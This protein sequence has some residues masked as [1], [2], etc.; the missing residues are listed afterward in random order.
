MTRTI[1][2]TRLQALIEIA[3]AKGGECLSTEYINAK[4]KMN[5]CCAEGHEW[6]ADADQI[7]NKGTW[8]PKCNKREKATI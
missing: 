6:I 4:T 7:K 1:N 3:N 8:C 5:W 2:I